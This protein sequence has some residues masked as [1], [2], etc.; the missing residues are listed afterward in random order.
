MSLSGFSSHFKLQRAIFSNCYIVLSVCNQMIS[1]ECVAHT[2]NMIH[3][4]L[5]LNKAQV[6][7]PFKMQNE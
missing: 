1:C 3:P 2:A 4:A 5:K 6:V 7:E